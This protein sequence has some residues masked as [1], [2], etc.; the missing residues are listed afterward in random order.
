MARSH[1]SRRRRAIKAEVCVLCVYSAKSISSTSKTEPRPRGTN[2]R[3]RPNPMSYFYP[4]A[5]FS[6]CPLLPTCSPLGNRVTRCYIFTWEVGQPRTLLRQQESWVGVLPRDM[7]DIWNLTMPPSAVG[8]S[9][10]WDMVPPMCPGETSVWRL[11][12]PLLL[13]SIPARIRTP[14]HYPWPCITEK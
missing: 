7:P 8:I 14:F 12:V 3:G 13:G 1:K 6:V 9:I 4:H 10:A 11:H 5:L 2:L